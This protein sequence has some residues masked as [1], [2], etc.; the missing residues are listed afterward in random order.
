MS[1]DSLAPPRNERKTSGQRGGK[2]R[3]EKLAP[4]ERKAIASLAADARWAKK[5]LA[6]TPDASHLLKATHGSPDRPL[7][8]GDVTIP[9]YVL[10]DG[11]RVLT[12]R[13][14]VAGLGMKYG[15]SS[16]GADR[17]TRFLGGSKLSLHVSNELR[18]LLANPLK[19][20]TS[21]GI[22]NG[23]PATI[24]ADICDAVLAA[25]KDGALQKQQ[26]HIAEQCEILVRGFARVGIIALVDEATGYQEQRKRDELHQLLAVYLSE[27]KLKWA[28][29]FPDEF[30]QHL[31]R[32]RGWAWPTGNNRTPYVGKLTNK[33]VYEMLPSGVLDELKQRNPTDPETG[34]RRHKHHQF[35][36]EDI[37][38]PDLRDHFL[39]LL[40]LMRV[41]K[42]WEMLEAFI[43]DGLPSPAR[44]ARV[45]GDDEAEME[46]EIEPE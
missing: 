34:R 7:K 42:T 44:S 46:V 20:R 22:A 14:L 13:G 3:A 21:G 6:E 27:E 15:S 23:Y 30:Y 35:L 40:P 37:G 31:Y 9:C 18:V 1:N 39:Q 26:A 16:K 25:R 2:V 5:K 12:Q 17:L 28:K 36:S 11:T 4:E 41:A 8:I 43:A 33:L 10:E 38:Q 45:A 19:F 29:R 24:L 32:L